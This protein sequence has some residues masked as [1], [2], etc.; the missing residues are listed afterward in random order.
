VEQVVVR[1]LRV[2]SARLDIRFVRHEHDIGISV[3]RRD[4]D[5]DV[6]SVK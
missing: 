4:R 2:G 5:V 6:V 1:R 3:L